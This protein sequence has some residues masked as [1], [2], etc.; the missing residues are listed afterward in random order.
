M[1]LFGCTTVWEMCSV[2]LRLRGV[3]QDRFRSHVHESIPS[4][5]ARFQYR[6]WFAR[7]NLT[8]L[9]KSTNFT[10]GGSYLL[11]C[12]RLDKWIHV[13]EIENCEFWEVPVI[14]HSSRHQTSNICVSES[15]LFCPCQ[16]NV[17]HLC[18]DV[19]YLQFYTCADLLHTFSRSRSRSCCLPDVSQVCVHAVCGM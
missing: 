12:C 10:F 9:K 14:H 18:P 19:F 2:A 3:S 8:C 1:V 11:D 5:T 13:C 4:Y 6:K 7:R 15:L 16:G 17:S